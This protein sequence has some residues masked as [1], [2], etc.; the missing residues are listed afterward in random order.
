MQKKMEKKN[1]PKSQF[2]TLLGLTFKQGYAR[3]GG[4]I[5][6]GILFLAIFGP[7]FAPYTFD[8]FVDVVV[9]A[10]LLSAPNTPDEE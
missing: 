7:F 4:A 8:E 6:L 3:L 2:R 1:K 5:V 9:N 10:G